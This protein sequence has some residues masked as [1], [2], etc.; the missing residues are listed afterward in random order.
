MCKRCGPLT[1]RGKVGRPRRG[2]G[3]RR[4]G[5][6]GCRRHALSERERVEA[7][8]SQTQP[9]TDVKALLRVAR[10]EAVLVGRPH[11]L[12][13]EPTF[14]LSRPASHAVR[15]GGGGARH[16]ELQGVENMLEELLVSGGSRN[17][18]PPWGWFPSAMEP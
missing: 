14:V 4:R 5:G 16:V 9:Y 12:P 11:S 3:R 10:H 13:A 8:R 2:P 1:G 15:P 7:A 18:Q 17:D 6:T